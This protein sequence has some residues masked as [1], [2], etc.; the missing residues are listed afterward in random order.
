MMKP[1]MKPALLLLFCFSVASATDA[2]QGRNVFVMPMNHGLDQFIANQLTRT[3]LMQV[4]TDPQKADTVITDRV[5]G[6]LEDRLKEMYPPPEEKE[7]AEPPQ[8]PSKPKA[9]ASKPD[10]TNGK[11]E[12][13]GE[14]TVSMLADAASKG[15]SRGRMAVGGRGR[16]TVFLV[17]VKSRQVLWSMFEVPQSFSPKALDRTAERIVKRLQQDVTTK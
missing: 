6:N 16:G 11:Q 15:D 7:A 9:D 1:G 5:G 14:A 12:T 13:A 10:A 2:I 3:H 17:D 8:K 4:V